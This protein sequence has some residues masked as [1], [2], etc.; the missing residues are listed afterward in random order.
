MLPATFQRTALSRLVAPTPMIAEVIV[1][2]LPIG[3][4][5][6]DTV[7]ARRKPRLSLLGWPFRKIHRMASMTRKPAI[8]PTTG[9]RIIG[10]RTF[11]TMPDHFTFSPATRLAPTRPPISACDEDD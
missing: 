1:W 6:A 10:S 7:W 9:D 4:A 8:R 3:M 11:S 2:V 5:A